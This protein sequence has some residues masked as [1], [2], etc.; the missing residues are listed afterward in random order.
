MNNEISNKD[1][2][3]GCENT[4]KVDILYEKFAST[5]SQLLEKIN[6]LNSQLPELFRII[7]D[8]KVELATLSQT[9]KNTE[10]EFKLYLQQ[11]TEDHRQIHTKIK[12]EYSELKTDTEKDYNKKIDKLDNRQFEIV[13]EV[14]QSIGK[15][16]LTPIII[17]MI[18]LLIGIITFI[19]KL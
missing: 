13:K 15:R 11:N 3:I 5:N 19:I 18:S 1:N 12:R 10:T 2:C 16:T 17:S 7:S 8:H 9:V 4:T 6:I 14:N